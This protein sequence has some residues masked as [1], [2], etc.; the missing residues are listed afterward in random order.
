LL[1]RI[2]LTSK[3]LE[4]TVVESFWLSVKIVRSS[5]ECGKAVKRNLEDRNAVETIKREGRL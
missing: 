5:R 4:G 1:V 3:F 2:E